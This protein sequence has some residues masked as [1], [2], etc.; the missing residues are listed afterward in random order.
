MPHRNRALPQ[1]APGFL[2]G[3]S[4]PWPAPRQEK[5]RPGDTEAV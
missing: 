1:G 5:A 2:A 4:A 3:A